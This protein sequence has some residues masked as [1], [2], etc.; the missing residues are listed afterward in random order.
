VVSTAGG[1]SLTDSQLKS[2]ESLH[3]K[4]SLSAICKA[5]CRIRALAAISP[6]S[7]SHLLV[8]AEDLMQLKSF[9]TA[10][11]VYILKRG[12]LASGFGLKGMEEAVV[13][14]AA[15]PPGA[16]GVHEGGS[17]TSSKNTWKDRFSC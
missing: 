3:R 16:D 11:G 4:Q 8:T 7:D 10:A 5:A 2:N 12:D 9:D 14:R 6:A 17:P 13:R 1:R 15:Q